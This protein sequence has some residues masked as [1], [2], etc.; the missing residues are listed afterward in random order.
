MVI[1]YLSKQDENEEDSN[2]IRSK[3]VN[4]LYFLYKNHRFY[5]CIEKFPA[6]LINRYEEEHNTKQMN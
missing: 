6:R 2:T 5:H 4:E 3:T 1:M